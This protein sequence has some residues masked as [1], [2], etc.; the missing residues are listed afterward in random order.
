ML[1]LLERLIWSITLCCFIKFRNINYASVLMHWFIS[2]LF[3]FYLKSR[4][5]ILLLALVAS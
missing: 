2:G 4:L 1:I 3:L 5:F